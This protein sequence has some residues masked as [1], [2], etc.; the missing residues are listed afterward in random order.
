[1]TLHADLFWCYKVVFGLAKVQSDNGHVLYHESMY[2]HAWRRGH[3]YK[4]Y[5]RHS[6]LCRRSTFFTER[7]L[8]TWKVGMGYLAMLIL[9]H[10]RA[11]SVLLNV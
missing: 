4:L 2:S 10:F 6:N 8:N 7:V 9:A 11:L 1:M 5:K 3:K